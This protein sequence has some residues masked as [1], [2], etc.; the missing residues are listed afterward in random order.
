MKIEPGY[1]NFGNQLDI[2]SLIKYIDNET[3]TN[4]PVNKKEKEVNGEN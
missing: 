4:K 2:F 1:I 3:E